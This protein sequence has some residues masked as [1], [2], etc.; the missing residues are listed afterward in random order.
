LGGLL[1]ALFAG[2]L[3]RRQSCQEELQLGN[4]TFNL[5]YFVLRNISPIAVG[6]VFLHAVGVFKWVGIG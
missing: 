2:H 1:T 3:M 5:W 6:I 4:K